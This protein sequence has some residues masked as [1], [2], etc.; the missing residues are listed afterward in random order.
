[1]AVIWMGLSFVGSNTLALTI[2]VV[3]GGVYTIGFLELVQF[4][5]AT[6]T[7]SG[8]LAALPAGSGEKLADLDGWLARLHPSLHN[9]V[10]LRIEGER[11]G[12]PAPAITP[13]LVGLLVMLGLLG[14][15]AGMVETLRGA[16]F[17]LEGTT[18][19]QAIRAGLAAPIKGLSLAFGTSVAGVAASA[20]LGLAA[21][22]TRRDRML[23]TRRLDGRIAS[24][25]RNFSLI[26]NRQETYQ[27]LQMQARA[28]PEVAEQLH[29]LATKLEG[30]GDKLG[31]KLIANQ[32][33]FHSSVQNIYT[34]LANSVDRSLQE[35]LAASGR[36]AGDSIRP[37][38]Q[39]AMTAVSTE[40]RTTHQQMSSLV[41][42]QLTALS[43]RFGDTSR[44]VSDAWRAG[45]DAHQQSNQA[46][47]AGMSASFE[48]FNGQFEQ[49]ATA[50]L[51]AFDQTSSS[52]L[53]RQAEGDSQRLQRWTSSLEQSQASAGSQLAEAS[54]LFAGELGHVAEQQQAAFTTTTREFEAMSAALTSQWLQASERMDELTT[55]LKSELSALRTDEETRGQAAVARM[56]DLEATVASH[57]A[58]LG[59]ELEEPMTRLIQTASETPRAAA[60]V[61]G[62]LRQEIS[63]NIERDNSLLEERR[64]IMQELNTLSLSLEQASA[65][66]RVA[67]EQLVNASTG[68][69][70]DVSERFTG[71]VDTELTRMT[72]AAENFAGSATEIS[73]LGEAFGLAVTLFSE[74]NGQLIDSLGRIES[75]MGEST[76][77]SD[78]QMGYYVAQAREIIDQSM[79]SQREIFEEL[80]QLGKQDELMPVEAS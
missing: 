76:S 38:V 1:M 19:L 35:S 67:I 8:A 80:R 11:V 15:F 3:I 63:N 61:I 70:Q 6:A 44:E 27:A 56:A 77:R 33:H 31:D 41:A 54:Q 75:A 72:E 26:H 51:T 25:F 42:E 46:L 79:S 5:Q 68:M 12:L 21:T 52:W 71:Q 7:L 58:T 10:R 50:M 28:L 64:Q 55:T 47:V 13:Y 17:A 34:E 24:V 62:H 14:T 48:S 73:S 59:K 66:Q 49:A 22:L 40:A 74:A 20:M 36:Q 30:M 4:R 43:S 18:E 53:E 37:L 45:L 9:A 78:E 69:L 2:T 60:E 32:E 16:V 65:G 23:E 57:L 39:D 29:E